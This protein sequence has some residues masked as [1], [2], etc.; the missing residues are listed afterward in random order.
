MY[1]KSKL[2]NLQSEI[3]SPDSNEKPRVQKA[4][5][6]CPKRATNGSSF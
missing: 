2:V 4:N 5:F 1:E 3:N 6:S